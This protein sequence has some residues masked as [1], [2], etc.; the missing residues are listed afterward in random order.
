M[1]R[2]PN[3][4]NGPIVGKVGTVIGSSRN[5]K[6]YVKG[7]HKLRTKKVSKK[8]LGNRGKFAKA[9][10]WLKPLLHFVQEGYLKYK[11]TS[12]AFVAAKSYLLLNAFEG[13]Q[14]DIRI[15]P[16]LMK[17]SVGELPLSKDMAVEKTADYQL[18]FT[19][20]PAWVTGGSNYDQVMMLAY[21]VDHA[22]ASFRT[23]GQFRN[24]GIDTLNLFQ[25]KGRTYHVYMAFTADDRSSQSDSVY[26][27]TIV[28]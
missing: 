4:I 17:V 9:Q 24:T 27:G 21:D 7:P 6:D 20:D 18:T 26:M 19:W 11:K 13:V 5:G 23:T 12:G 22:W 28:S 2:L 10:A 3:G 14:P 1:G 8:E 25:A 15:N 16:A